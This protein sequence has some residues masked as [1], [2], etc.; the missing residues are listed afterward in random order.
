MEA[1]FV[2]ALVVIAGVGAGLGFGRLALEA[3]FALVSDLAR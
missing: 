2:E 3:F 1:W